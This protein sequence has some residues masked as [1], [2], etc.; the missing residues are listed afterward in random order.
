MMAFCLFLTS[1]VTRVF[2]F[3]RVIQ[4]YNLLEIHHR[5][6]A[7]SRSRPCGLA[8]IS[9]GNERGKKSGK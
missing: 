5:N 9:I 2:L 7:V 4:N 6:I 8:V 1:P 3:F